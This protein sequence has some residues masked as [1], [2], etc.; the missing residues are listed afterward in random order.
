ML[1]MVPRIPPL[2][3]EIAIT[4][5]TARLC[6]CYSN[7]TENLESVLVPEVRET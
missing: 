6:G 1:D 7:L 5:I 3:Q 4:Q 2:P